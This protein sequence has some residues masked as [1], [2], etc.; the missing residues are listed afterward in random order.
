MQRV[1]YLLANFVVRYDASPSALAALRRWGTMTPEARR[2]VCHFHLQLTDPLYRAFTG[3]FLPERR[4][5]GLRDTVDFPLPYGQ[6]GGG[7]H[8]HR[9]CRSAS[10]ASV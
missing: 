9:S 8:G 7:V 6:P 10:H 1:R 3:D 5:A 4:G 2:L